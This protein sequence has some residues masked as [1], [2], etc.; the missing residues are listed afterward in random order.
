VSLA[1]ITGF[2]SRIIGPVASLIDDLHTSDEEKLI[3]KAKLMEIEKDTIAKAIDF[4]SELINAKKDIIVAEAKGQSWLQ[5]NWR[6]LLMMVCI[7]IIAN[8]YIIFPYIQLFFPEHAVMLELPNELFSLM[9]IGVGGYIVGRSGE[10][11]V[12]KWKQQ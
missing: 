1:L 6:P 9:S 10:K 8:N 11:I 4:E 7:T 5:R 2:V 12:T 3:M